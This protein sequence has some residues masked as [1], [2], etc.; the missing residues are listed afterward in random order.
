MEA[1]VRFFKFSTVKFEKSYK[2]RGIMMYYLL[3]RERDLISYLDLPRIK[4]LDDLACLL[5]FTKTQL[6]DFIANKDKH[7]ASFRI[8]KKHSTD[9]RIIN[10]PKKKLKMAQKIIL[11]EILQKIPCSEAST[12]F[13]KNKNGL[14]K[15]ALIHKEKVFLL[16]MDFKNFFQCIKREK[17]QK[18][19]MEL[20]YDNKTSDMLTGLCTFFNELPQ[21]GICSP[22]LSNL[23]CYKLDKEI[24]EFCNANNISYTRYADD[25]M[26]SAN[27]LEILKKLKNINLPKIIE[28]NRTNYFNIELN[29]EKTKLVKNTSHKKVTG[30][31]I[32]DGNMKVSKNKKNKVRAILYF[33]YK[34]GEFSKINNETKESLIGNISYIQSIEEDYLVKCIKYIEKLQ[35][36]F[37]REDICG[38]IKTLK[39]M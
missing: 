13:I 27:D 30:I 29:T 34:T 33:L 12:A 23:A 35:K 36:K 25:L 6:N 19:F 21:G 26:F 28:N 32:N 37:S 39:K 4:D 38:I 3:N 22:Y 8:P 2:V 14:L 11:V 1:S 18:I 31:T 20:G 17:I 24:S 7:Y 15:N 16:K 10:A 5:L 9:K